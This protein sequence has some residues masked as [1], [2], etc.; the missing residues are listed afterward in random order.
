MVH[1][2]TSVKEQK[3]QLLRLFIDV[4]YNVSKNQLKFRQYFQLQNYPDKTTLK[5][6]L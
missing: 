5:N 4:V 1:K 2:S 6:L 3:N